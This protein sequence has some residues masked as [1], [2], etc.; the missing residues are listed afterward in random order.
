MTETLLKRYLNADPNI[1]GGKVVF[2]G[3]RIP[4]YAVLELLE[5][6]VSPKE[7]LSQDYYPRLTLRHVQAALNYASRL[8]RQE[9]THIFVRTA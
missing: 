7:I 1:L 5:S 8:L 3:T 4:V 2:R 9:E 6:G